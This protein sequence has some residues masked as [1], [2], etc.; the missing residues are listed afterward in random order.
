MDNR[1]KPLVLIILDGWGVAPDGE[2]N[3]LTRAKTPNLNKYIHMYPTMTVMASGQEVGLSWGEMGN[4]EVG[5]LNIGAGRVYYQTFPRITKDITDGSFFDNAAFLRAGEH[6]KKNKSRLHIF[7]IVSEGNVHGALDHILA[8]LEVAKRQ[9]IED[10]YIHGFLDGRDA[11]YNSGKGFIQKLQKGIADKGVGEIA[12][13]SGRFYAMDR[14]NRYERVEAAYNAITYTGTE[15]VATATDPLEAITESYNKEVYDEQ[16]SP[17]VLTKRGKAVGSVQ[18]HDA[19]IFANFR[20]DRVRELTKAFVLPT[21]DKFKRKEF[22]DLVFVTMT[23]YENALPVTAI[24]YPPVVIKNS[25]AEVVSRAGL[26]QFHIAETE[27]YA[28]VTFF[29]NGTVEEPFQGEAREIIPSPHVA[30]YDQ[31]PEMSAPLIAKRTVEVI[32]QNTY[33]CIFLNFANGD[34]VAHTGNFDATVKGVE[35]VDVCIGM[36]VNAALAKNGVVLIT[37]DHGNAEEVVNLQTGEMDKEHSTNPVPFIVIGK[38]W[39]GQ[40]SP[41]GDPLGGDLSLM[42][43]VGVLADIA[44]TILKILQIPQPEEMTGQPLM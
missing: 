24:A 12:S 38:Q 17:T 1:P 37:A 28:H 25:L 10:V 14:D 5:H 29:L 19:V 36:I 18:E 44:P 6:V 8:L 31:Q 4:S 43:P 39:E 27:K 7:G 33:D 16:F 23:E 42:A 20:P 32:E 34:M 13:L 3:A 11:I 35:V 40:T 2:G 22:T 9:G 30:S 26:S 41:A 21:F 15:N